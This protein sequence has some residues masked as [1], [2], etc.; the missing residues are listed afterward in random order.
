MYIKNRRDSSNIKGYSSFQPLSY[1]ESEVLRNRLLFIYSPLGNIKQITMKK[2][3]LFCLLLLI[4]SCSET[5]TI[6]S[7]TSLNNQSLT[8]NNRFSKVNSTNANLTN[9]T[10]IGAWYVTGPEQINTLEE[11][12]VNLFFLN[13]HDYH[14]MTIEERDY[15]I[16]SCSK[17]LDN[18]SKLVLPIDNFLTR[19]WF[20][21]ESP[22]GN[23]GD[24]IEKWSDSTEVAGFLLRD[25]IITAD[26]PIEEDIIGYSKD[27]AIWIYRWYYKMIKNHAKIEDPNNP[28]NGFNMDISRGKPIMVSLDF[29]YPFEGTGYANYHN[30]S[31]LKTNYAHGVIPPNFFTPGDS[32]DVVMPYYYPH[33]T[34]IEL[35]TEKLIMNK[36]YK[37]MY[38]LFKNNLE[39]VI[40]LIQT[41]KEDYET[42]KEKWVQ[43]TYKGQEITIKYALEEQYDLSIQYNLLFNHGLLRSRSFIYYSVNGHREVTD[44]L[45]HVN[46]NNEII[47]TTPC[48]N[49]NT[50]SPCNRYY[51]EATILN[52]EHKRIFN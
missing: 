47:D 12:G 23:M 50:S 28:D 42:S 51:Q 6:N 39:S 19:K 10:N 4:I 18:N 44:N 41:V 22:K 33:R 13:R 48:D 52:T 32:W 31:S 7:D 5:E 20:N 16:E 49:T 43:T 11:I 29:G 27:N 15:F 9:N 21:N 34:N 35:H 1:L 17:A 40:P 24:F 8:S 38:E 45:L 25:D 30:N 3:K 46:G 2:I 14:E 37:D 26:P 36:V